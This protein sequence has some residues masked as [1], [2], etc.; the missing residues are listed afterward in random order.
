MSLG[1]LRG[2]TLGEVDL[3][4]TL[5]CAGER[6]LGHKIR[7]PLHVVVSLDVHHHPSCVSSRQSVRQAILDPN[8]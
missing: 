6:I 5:P 8:P 7:T 4:P 2:L 1:D 3:L